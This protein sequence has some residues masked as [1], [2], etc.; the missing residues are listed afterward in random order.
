MYQ[1]FGTDKSNLAAT[2]KR[3]LFKPFIIHIDGETFETTIKKQRP[4]GEVY[5]HGTK[6]NWDLRISAVGNETYDEAY[7]TQYEGLAAAI[8]DSLFIP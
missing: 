7:A 1:I 4:L 2:G 3:L 6:R 5:V 8:K